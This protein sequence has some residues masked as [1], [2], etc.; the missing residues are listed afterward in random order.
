MIIGLSELASVVSA[1]NC[2]VACE[3][4]CGTFN[5][6]KGKCRNECS[7]T[8]AS[9]K[10]KD[11]CWATCGKVC[12]NFNSKDSKEKCNNGCIK[13]CGPKA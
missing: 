4:V 2:M 3:A 1:D 5:P 13:T 8:C 6:D 10:I 11:T 9:P 7:K 12:A